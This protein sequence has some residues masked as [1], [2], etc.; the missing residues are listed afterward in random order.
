MRPSNRRSCR[1]RHT[2]MLHLASLAEV[3]D[4]AR[5]VFDRYVRVDAVLI[6]EIDGLYAESLQRAV[7]DLLD[8]LRTAGDPPSRLT[9]SRVDVPAEFGGDDHLPPKR[10]QRLTN[11]F[12][13]DVGTVDLGSVEEC[14]TPVHCAPDQRNH[15]LPIRLVAITPCHT[16][17]A[18]P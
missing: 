17:A 18:Q 9:R 5:D 12:F 4:G 16:H 14:D 3:F 8:H 10:S 2:E 11:E 6:V 7:D 1:L 13:V 15:L